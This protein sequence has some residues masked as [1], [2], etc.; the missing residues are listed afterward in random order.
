MIFLRLYEKRNLLQLL[1]LHLLQIDR[2][3]IP[4]VAIVAS[5]AVAKHKNGKAALSKNVK[6][7]ELRKKVLTILANRPDSQQEF[8]IDTSNQIS[9]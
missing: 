7:K 1:L 9:C 6:L 8:I 2:Y 4:S 5:V 3:L